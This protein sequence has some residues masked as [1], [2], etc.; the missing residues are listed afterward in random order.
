MDPS[1]YGA[2]VNGAEDTTG[3]TLI[4]VKAMCYVRHGVDGFTKFSQQ[5]N[6]QY[7]VRTE[8]EAVLK[9]AVNNNV[10]TQYKKV[11]CFAR[12]QFEINEGYRE[13][14]IFTEKIPIGTKPLDRYE[15]VH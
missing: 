2:L 1:K 14:V 9:F 6:E 8:E 13:F 4:R 10:S 7:L 15:I 3:L 12:C 11:G 5:I